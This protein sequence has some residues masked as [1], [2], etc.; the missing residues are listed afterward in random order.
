MMIEN[1]DGGLTMKKKRWV[2]EE[3]QQQETVFYCDFDFDC[4]FNSG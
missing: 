2:E 1:Y 4:D 3:E